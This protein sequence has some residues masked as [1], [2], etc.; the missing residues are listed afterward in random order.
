MKEEETDDQQSE[1]EGDDQTVFSGKAD[2]RE[3]GSTG[4]EVFRRAAAVCLYDVSGLLD[5]Q[6]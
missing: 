6:L 5:D 3:H 1:T 2:G 4:A